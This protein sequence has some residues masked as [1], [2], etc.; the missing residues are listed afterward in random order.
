MVNRDSCEDAVME[1]APKTKKQKI[2]LF[3]LKTIKV[4]SIDLY[5][6]KRK[7]HRYLNPEFWH[8]T[9]IQLF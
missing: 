2:K 8:Q 4:L 3:I 7:Y 1:T 9:V 5:Q 6:Q